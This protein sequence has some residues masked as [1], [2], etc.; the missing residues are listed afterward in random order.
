LYLI[1]EALNGNTQITHINLELGRFYDER[2]STLP[3]RLVLEAAKA[4]GPLLQYIQ[5]SP[6]LVSITLTHRKICDVNVHG[7][8]AGLFFQAT[9]TNP[10]AKLRELCIDQWENIDLARADFAHLMQ[11]TSSLKKLEISVDSAT[12]STWLKEA[13]QT[14]TTLE[15]LDVSQAHGPCA[16]IFSALVLHPRLRELVLPVTSYG[17]GDTMSFINSLAQLLSSTTSLDLLDLGPIDYSRSAMQTLSSALQV[18]SSITRLLF[19]HDSRFPARDTSFPGYLKSLVT[20]PRGLRQLCYSGRAD[21]LVEAMV[22]QDGAS[23]TQHT[24][25]S[26]LQELWLCGLT[27]FLD[28]YS[29]NAAM[30]HLKCLTVQFLDR[31]SMKDLCQCFPQPCPSSG[32]ELRI[33]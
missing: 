22:P 30:I 21:L 24:V 29:S 16:N 14:N 3:E 10:H 31:E 6:S 18:N 11:T 25:G 17:Q 8:L 23:L 32:I 12:D 7:Q 33:C 28:S 4:A 15:C 9:A 1:G 26:A 13:L 2:V 27:G 5:T 19:H 20:K